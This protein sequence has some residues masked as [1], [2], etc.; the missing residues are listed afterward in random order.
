V[1]II[2]GSTDIVIN[3]APVESA[4]APKRPYRQFGM[5]LSGT[6]QR[7]AF[8]Y[9]A[10]EQ[11]IDGN[12]PPPCFRSKAAFGFLR[13]FDA[14]GAA[15]FNVRNEPLTTELKRLQKL[16]STGLGLRMGA[17]AQSA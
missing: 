7:S 17:A 15:F 8:V 12:A 3:V 11:C 1:S 13:D 6:G 16:L 4:Y 2:P 10:F 9:E 14:D 5:G